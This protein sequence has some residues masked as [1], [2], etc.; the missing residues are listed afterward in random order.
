MTTNRVTIVVVPRER[1]SYTQ[2]SLES[3]YANTTYPFDL[4][5]V[6]GNSP[7]QV[8]HYLQT[9]ATKYG[10][11]IVRSNRYLFPNQ[12]RNLGI[13]HAETEYIAFLDN[14]VLV[15]PGWLEA[16]VNCCDRNSAD[17]AVPMTLEGEPG[18]TIHQVGGTLLLKETQDGKRWLIERRPF[19]HLPL[20]KVRQP[21]ESG[22]TELG[23]FHCIFAR[24]DLFATIGLL[25]EQ[26]INMAEE[27][28]F[29]LSAL[30]A[31]KKIYLEPAS[32]V[33]YVVPKTLARSDL[34]FFFMRWSDDACQ[35]SIERMKEKYALSSDSPAFKHYR[36]F[37]YSQRLIAFGKTELKVK[38]LL[39]ASHLSITAKVQYLIKK[40]LR[41]RMNHY[42]MHSKQSA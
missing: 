16:L 25:D 39:W 26:I 30:Q 18:D 9:A 22:P 33:T 28:D 5:Y 20:A 34:A 10:F 21:I 3:I 1:F 24:R 6:D 7:T 37:V 27:S 40:L 17:I 23:E 13:R 36:S 11:K 14:D 12:A 4:V 8:R 42:A 15:Q 35:A 29:C 2:Q 19:M 41:Y 32:R 31:G 38:S